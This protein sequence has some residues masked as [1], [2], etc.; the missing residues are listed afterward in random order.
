MNKKIL[1]PLVYCPYHQCLVRSC[2]HRD[3]GMLE[4]FETKCSICGFHLKLMCPN[5]MKDII[6]RVTDRPSIGLIPKGVTW[7]S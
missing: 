7:S 2:E 5:C 4:K 1:P 6:D 3:E